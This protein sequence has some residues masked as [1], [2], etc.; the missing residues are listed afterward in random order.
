[1]LLKLAIPCE[2]VVAV[3]TTV[4]SFF[5]NSNVTPSIPFEVSASVLLILILP[6]LKSFVMF[7]VVVLSCS[8]LTSNIVVF[9]T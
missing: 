6:F 3:A 5:C 2:L 7:F 4:P 8:T 9:Y 1:M